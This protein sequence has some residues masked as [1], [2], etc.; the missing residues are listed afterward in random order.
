MRIDAYYGV[1]RLATCGRVEVGKRG[2]VAAR[3][4]VNEL[5]VQG[6][7]HGEVVALERVEVGPKGKVF[8]DL[9][10]PR[11][12]VAAG[13]VVVGRLEVGPHA[14]AGAVVATAGPEVV[15]KKSPGGR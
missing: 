7:V 2:H 1:V 4:R 3:V 15:A 5:V 10:T 14:L 11:L 8:G 12:E 9:R 6:T 13:G